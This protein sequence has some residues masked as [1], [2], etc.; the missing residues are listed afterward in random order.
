M[1]HEADGAVRGRARAWAVAAHH[2]LKAARVCQQ[3]SDDEVSGEKHRQW[4]SYSSDNDRWWS[5]P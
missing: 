4:G 2:A 3:S 1:A 5:S